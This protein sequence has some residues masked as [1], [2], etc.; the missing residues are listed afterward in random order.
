MIQRNNISDKTPAYHSNR[1]ALIKFSL[2]LIALLVIS[3][4]T[5]I[6]QQ[7]NSSLRT[8]HDHIAQKLALASDFCVEAL[9]K[10]DFVSIEHF[11]N[12]WAQGHKNIIALR[13]TTEN[14]FKLID[15]QHVSGSTHNMSLKKITTYNGVPILTLEV[16]EDLDHLYSNLYKRAITLGIAPSLTVAFFGIL[17]WKSIYRNAITPLQQEIKERIAIEKQLEKR[18]HALEISNQELEAFSYSV[19]HDLRSPLRAIDGYSAALLED[20]EKELDEQGKDYLKGIRR[21]AQNMAA[22]IDDLLSLSQVTRHDLKLQDVDMSRLMREI[23]TSLQTEYADKKV[24]LIIEDN[25]HA[26]G[27]KKLLQ[28]AMRNLMDN[29]WKYT[30][31]K[32]IASIHFGTLQE[33]ERLV[34]F[35]KDNGAGFNMAY[36]DKLFEPFQRLHRQDEFPGSGIGLAIV[37]R[38]IQRHGGHIWADSIPDQGSIFYFTIS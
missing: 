23:A 2:A 11:L 6:I 12:S 29:A 24:N 36:Q 13:A 34:Y 28:I 9:L 21:G 10:N 30:N 31:N 27:D 18:T 14:G 26:K 1:R 8:T 35:L 19:S 20:C 32:S 5:V 22:L 37:H 4:I 15:F 17:L 38:V 25:M 16:V 7:H 33:N 3:D